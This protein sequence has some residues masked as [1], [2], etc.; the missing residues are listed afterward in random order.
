[1]DNKLTIQLGVCVLPVGF[2]WANRAV[3]W[4]LSQVRNGISPYAWQHFL[5]LNGSDTTGTG[6]LLSVP[7]GVNYMDIVK[8]AVTGWKD[9]TSAT[10]NESLLADNWPYPNDRAAA[11][12][13][14]AKEILQ[15][16]RCCGGDASSFSFISLIPL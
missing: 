16:E 2:H 11:W 5:Q 8:V 15:V 12:M 9:A 6:E 13:A 14:V 7:S 4:A 10:S 3:R 1:M